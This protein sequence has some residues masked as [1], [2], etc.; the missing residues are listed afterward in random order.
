MTINFSNTLLFPAVKIEGLKGVILSNSSSP[1]DSQKGL[2][3]REEDYLHLVIIIAKSMHRSW[4]DCDVEDL[5][6]DGFFGL[7]RAVE[8]FD[9]ERGVKFSTFAGMKIVGAIKDGMRAR[10]WVPRNMRSRAEVPTIGTIEFLIEKGGRK[11]ED[12]SPD[13]EELISGLPVQGKTVVRLMFLEG[14]NQKQAA[15]RMGLSG[16]RVSQ[17]YR[18][19]ME[20]LRSRWS[21]QAK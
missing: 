11:R 8:L 1:T 5:I 4:Y 10:D 7:R 17:I 14:L 15:V 20:W 12:L 19:S 9:P 16:G 6:S 13:F 21:S 3:I 2:S 18:E